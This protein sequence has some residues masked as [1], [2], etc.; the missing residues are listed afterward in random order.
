MIVGAGPGGRGRDDRPGAVPALGT[1]RTLLRAMV[2]ISALV[3][4]NHLYSAVAPRARGGIALVV[5]ALA[6]MWCIDLLLYATTYLTGRAPNELI[7]GRGAVMVLAAP[8]VAIAVQRNGDWTLQLSRTVAW[9]TLTFAITL[10]YSRWP[11]SA[12]PARSRRSAA[13]MR[14]CCRPPSCSDR[15]PLSL[16]SS[17]RHWVRAWAKVKVAKHFFRHRYDYRA[18]WTRF[19]DTLGKPGEGAARSMSGSSRQSPT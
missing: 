11:C 15:P 6:G 8:V 12:R 19:T 2:A 17:P 3:L 5:F 1:V 13:T 14:V 18:E 9:Q 10:L 7:A 16:P 4:V